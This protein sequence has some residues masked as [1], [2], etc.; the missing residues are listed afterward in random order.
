MPRPDPKTR[1]MLI[2]AGVFIAFAGFIG[3]SGVVYWAVIFTLLVVL[4]LW[5]Y[6][7]EQSDYFDWQSRAVLT[8]LGLFTA[9][10]VAALSGL[11]FPRSRSVELIAQPGAYIASLPLEVLE[12]TDGA[13][14]V[15]VALAVTMMVV[16]GPKIGP[17]GLGIT[18]AAIASLAA[19]GALKDVDEGFRTGDFSAVADA[20]AVIEF[21]WLIVPVA[22]LLGEW[23]HRRHM[24]EEL[25]QRVQAARDSMRREWLE[26]QERQNAIAE[27][28]AF[29]E[30]VKEEGSSTSLA[31][32]SI[33]EAREAGEPTDSEIDQIEASLFGTPMFWDVPEEELREVASRVKIERFTAGQALF[34][35]GDEQACL[36]IIHRGVVA[37]RK[38][39]SEDGE[40]AEIAKLYPGT[41]IGEMALV[42]QQARSASGIAVDEVSV[43]RVDADVLDTLIERL[44]HI[45][46]KIQEYLLKTVAQRLQTSSYAMFGEADV[47][48]EVQGQ[49]GRAQGEMDDVNKDEIQAIL[50]SIPLFRGFG[51]E[52]YDALS[53]SLGKIRFEAGADLAVKGD[54]EACMYVLTGGRAEVWLAGAEGNRISLAEVGTGHSVGEMGLFLDSPR[55]AN[56]SAKTTV[57]ALVIS[58]SALHRLGDTAPV[59]AVDLYGA[60]LGLMSQRLR[61]TSAQMATHSGAVQDD[62]EISV[63]LSGDE[64]TDAASSED[65]VVGARADGEVG[66]ADIEEPEFVVS[67]DDVDPRMQVDPSVLRFRQCA[68]AVG[69]VAVIAA[70]CWTSTPRWAQAVDELPSSATSVAVPVLKPGPATVQVAIDPF[71]PRG[72]ALKVEEADIETDDKKWPCLPDA[73]EGEA[74][75]G[76]LPRRVVT[77]TVDA[78][79]TVGQLG[80][81][82]RGIRSKGNYRVAFVGRAS[83]LHGVGERLAGWPVVSVLVDRPPSASHWV[84]LNK[85]GF[86]VLEPLKH[87]GRAESCAIVADP[88]VSL[89]HLVRTL[90]DFSRPKTI[91]NC[92]G[93]YTLVL[94]DDLDPSLQHPGWQGCR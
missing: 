68:S 17:V 83:G 74:A 93:V 80:P 48:Q 54:V 47:D 30:T 46:V 50:T 64:S 10:A 77:L 38:S 22:A 91:P 72:R 27:S 84:R 60:L 69:Q 75:Y 56:V 82:I 36:F 55:T 9:G 25:T 42:D 5:V 29:T 81:F 31:S 4:M 78:S 53:V 20:T 19:R 61:R 67:V 6:F 40:E 14:G 37:I 49:G 76:T 88:A 63:E 44:P 13:F 16:V 33:A 73:R 66:L 51:P 35:E 45:G 24:K 41:V 65:S 70:L 8:S 90:Q 15:L 52:A 28:P 86:D 26:N 12:S 71:S 89:Q 18:G 39:V 85:S 79:R 92:K 59:V 3:P 62:D 21:A 23:A 43:I 1:R 2:T 7:W 57:H 32:P 94:A 58:R 11:S 34:K 87:V